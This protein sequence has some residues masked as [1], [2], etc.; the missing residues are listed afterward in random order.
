MA[1]PAESMWMMI[2]VILLW[3]TDV[4]PDSLCA[5]ILNT[6][7]SK[8]HSMHLKRGHQKNLSKPQLQKLSFYTLGYTILQLRWTTKKKSTLCI[9]S[10]QLKNY[11]YRLSSCGSNDA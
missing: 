1:L 11:K 9:H 10:H 5:W 2:T 8:A 4:D 7:F 6:S 3:K